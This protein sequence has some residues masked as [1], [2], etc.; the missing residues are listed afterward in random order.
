[1][2]TMGH[3][4]TSDIAARLAGSRRTNADTRA[5]LQ[6]ADTLLAHANALIARALELIDDSDLMLHRGVLRLAKQPHHNRR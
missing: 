4:I 3:H 6:R 5:R 2:E 1:M